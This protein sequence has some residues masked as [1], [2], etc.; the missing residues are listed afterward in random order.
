MSQ[1]QQPLVSVIVPC[2]NYGKFLPYT[3][4]SVLAQTYTNWECIIVNDGSADDTETVAK[5]YVD[6]DKRF[7]YLYQSNQG[8]A[9]ARNTGIQQAKGEYIQL[10]DAD[11]LIE[12][13]KF[14]LQ[15]N[16]L[17]EEPAVDIVYGDAAFFKSDEPEV[18]LAARKPGERSNN[19]LKVSGKGKKIIQQIARDNFIEV[20]APLLKHS[21][22]DEVGLFDVTYRSYEDWLF[23][24]KCAVAGLEFAYQPIPGTKTL[25][26]FG[27]TSLLTNNKHLVKV[28][29][30]LRKYMHGVLSGSI[31]GYNAYR[32]LKL[33][34]KKILLGI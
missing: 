30:E 4:Q 31:K 7:V 3:L 10:L 26:R 32:L 12:E 28:G 8:L 27:H 24:F 11:D 33:Y 34:V 17:E 2:Y 5:Q 9:A 23:W 15:V 6:S 20:S 16:F 25:I 21:V 14:E 18:H 19:E 29:I 22:F 13:N 1:T